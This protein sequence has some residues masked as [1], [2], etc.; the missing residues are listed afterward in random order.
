MENNEGYQR[1]KRRVRK[2]REFYQ[3]L[4][5]YLV[6]NAFLFIINR[7]TDP[8]HSWFIWPLL[9]WGI[10]VVM[11]GF[12]VFAEGGIWGKEWEERKIQQILEKEKQKNGS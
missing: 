10:G 2:I 4:V 1:A 9:G 7:L 6:V 3:H 11:H 12:S 5:T 8:G